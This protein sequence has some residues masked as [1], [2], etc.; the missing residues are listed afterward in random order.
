MLK[1]YV[2]Y[3]QPRHEKKAH[4][5]LQSKGYNTY[6]PLQTTIKQWSDRKKKVEV[7]VFNSYLFI[8]TELEKSRTDILGTAGIVKFVTLGKEIATIKEEQIKQIKL[9]LS[10]FDD[11]DI[12]ASNPFQLKQRVEV[13]AGP[14]SGNKGILVEHKG[15]NYFAI[16]FEA[17][18]SN[19]LV[20][21]PFNYLRKI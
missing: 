17:L 20:N 13:I 8:E 11:I 18:G 15:T 10:E 21:I 12:L 14:F 16:E 4:Q 19:I 6:L 2:L 7:P 5:V 1:W 3:T 9:L